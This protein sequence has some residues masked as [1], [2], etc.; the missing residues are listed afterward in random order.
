[1]FVMSRRN[2]LLP[3]PNGERVFLKK[4]CVASVPEWAERSGYFQAL[5][6][7]GKVLLSTGGKDFAA[8]EKKGR[9]DKGHSDVLAR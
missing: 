2:I 3:G 9:K 1:M 5:A 4:D 8:R 7:D 6:A